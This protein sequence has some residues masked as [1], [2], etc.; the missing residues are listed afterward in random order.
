[1]TPK[2]LFII[3]FNRIV[4]SI[5]AIINGKTMTLLNSLAIIVLANGTFLMLM[6]GPYM[7]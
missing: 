4:P 1:M 6:M 7:I 3:N 2:L 5:G